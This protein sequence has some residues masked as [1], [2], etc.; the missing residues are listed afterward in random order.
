MFAVPDIERHNRPD[1]SAVFRS[2]TALGAYPASVAAMLR[3]WAD[4]EPDHPLIAERDPA[5]QWRVLTYRQVRQ[6]ADAVGQALLDRG[7]GPQKPLMILSGNSIAHFLMM[8]G[9][10]TAGIPVAP[11]SVAYRNLST[12][13]RH[14]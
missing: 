12:C 5:G 4:I 1:G 14:R 9:A 2:R 10:L 3:S 8:L 13:L 7:L 6:D 11:V